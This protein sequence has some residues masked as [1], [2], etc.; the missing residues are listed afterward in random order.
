M[1]RLRQL[2]EIFFDRAEQRGY[3]LRMHTEVLR[4]DLAERRRTQPEVLAHELAVEAGLL[5]TEAALAILDAREGETKEY[6]L[7]RL[8]SIADATD[9]P[10]NRGKGNAS[11]GDTHQGDTDFQ[12]LDPDADSDLTDHRDEDLPQLPEEYISSSG[13]SHLEMRPP[14]VRSGESHL[15]MEL[16]PP[17]S[18]SGESLFDDPGMVPELETDDDLSIEDAPV[19]DLSAETLDDIGIEALETDDSEM[20]KVSRH[21][22]ASTVGPDTESPPRQSD[23]EQLPAPGPGRST[24]DGNRH[25]ETIETPGLPHPAQQFRFVGSKGAQ[26]DFSSF[27]EDDAP[28]PEEGSEEESEDISVNMS[29]S[30]VNE[31]LDQADDS[32]FG[33]A[34]DLSALPME[35]LADGGVLSGALDEVIDDVDDYSDMISTAPPAPRVASTPV[36]D[37][38]VRD[39]DDEAIVLDETDQEPDLPVVG[40]AT[41]DGRQEHGGRSITGEGGHRGLR[42]RTD[43]QLGIESAAETRDTIDVSEEDETD[44]SGLEQITG[45]ELSLADLRA[46]MG[47]GQG[48]KVGVRRG[49]SNRNAPGARR[50]YTV[51]R[52]IARGG[53]GKIIEV[54]DNDLRRR[55]ALKILRKE[56]LE[57]ADLVERFL[58][59]AQITGQLEHPNIVPVHE[60]G[61][62]GKGNLYFTMK[63]VQGEELSAI[64]RRLRKG[65]KAAAKAYPLSR[66]IDIYLKVC[67]GVAFAHSNGVIHRDLKPANIMVGRY[68]EVQI[69]DW[70][71]AKIV[72]RPEKSTDRIIVSDRREDDS[73]R[74]MVGSLLGT[75]SYMSPEQARGEVDRMG[76]AS[77]IFSLGT[78]LYQLLCLSTPWPGKTSDLVIDQ[79]KSFDPEPPSARAPERRIPPELEQL[80]MKCLVKQQEKRLSSAQDLV[81]NLRSWQ[82]GRTLTAV[83]YSLGQLLGK[84]M[85]RNKAVVITSLLVFAALIAGG[86]LTQR[87]LEQRELDR[88]DGLVAQADSKLDRANQAFAA[89]EYERAR[90][91]ASEARD[92]F[93]SAAVIAALRD[94]AREAE[95]EAIMLMTRASDTL[96]ERERRQREA[97]ERAAHEQALNAALLDARSAME[98]ARD[99]HADAL[100]SAEDISQA[101]TRAREEWQEVQLLERN[102]AEAGASIA[103]IETMQRGLESRRQA[104]QDLRRLSEIVRQ[105]EG[106]LTEAVELSEHDYDRA[107]RDLSEVRDLCIQALAV[108]VT[109]EA[110][111]PMR[112]RALRT[113][114][115]AT[116]E[117]ANR[118][119]ATQRYA[120]A[121]FLLPAAGTGHLEAEFH[122]ARERLEMRLSEQSR[123][124]QLLEDAQDA[125]R[126]GEWLVAVPSLEAALQEARTSRYAEPG[127]AQ[128]VARLLEYAKIEELRTRVDAA[129][130]SGQLEPLLLEFDS[131]IGDLTVDDYI[132]RAQRHRDNARLNLGQML[133]NEA[134]EVQDLAA[135]VDLYTRSLRH[136]TD[137]ALRADV[138]RRLREARFEIATRQLSDRVV[139]LPQGT[140]VLGSN[141]ESDRNPQRQHEH[142]EFVFMHRNLVTNLEFKQFV[143]EGGYTDATHWPEEALPHLQDFV[144]TTGQ[145]GPA[146]WV[147]GGFDSSLAH[148]PVTGISWYEAA[149]YAS[150]AGK[151]LPT[152]EEWEIAA[153]AQMLGESDNPPDY[154]FGSRED[155]PPGGVSETREVGSTDW[156]ASRH[157]VRDL[158]SNV[159][160]WTSQL[161]GNQGR[162]VVK[163]AEPGMGRELFFRYARRAKNSSAPLLD[164][165]P[166]RGFRCMEE[167]SLDLRE[168]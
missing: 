22:F 128:R 155:A 150:W 76:P 84:W 5:T 133:V 35:L 103:Q 167:L 97:E 46:Q 8:T 124:R 157:G 31:L 77:D 12:S 56:M 20:G 68:G 92:D 29:D 14:P 108:P 42:D 132:S 158:G 40:A 62:D 129:Q 100:A 51:V 98:H 136:I 45:Q 94:D 50:R 119:I 163:G 26:D 21:E 58:E 18:R 81:E 168:E 3:L 126:R 149:A 109:G 141:R 57:R 117:L 25:T 87:H 59:E 16:P 34:A 55:V 138:R 85:A 122:A 147:D 111:E 19:G 74:T 93:R 82:E 61:V 95:A 154:A 161:N 118:A 156:D 123:F 152:P 151:R 70:G 164:R 2:D 75:P 63:L 102:N 131:L 78:I 145:P 28:T 105:A 120:V 49:E 47:L 66:L 148:H 7:A 165:S 125:V 54:E 116:L 140:F 9:R 27:G 135:R 104:E 101:L 121:A 80:A 60:I 90:S 134:G 33:P 4:Q 110:A 15:E 41:E 144:D 107:E 142:E 24:V 30:A 48:V 72:G 153:G 139:L 43:S 130:T 13:E 52:Q 37:T 79:V 73:A 88:A 32:Y 1:N 112:E 6:M 11:S 38:Q 36:H 86:I 166:G 91:L 99:L 162:A 10:P 53:M 67:E 127:D 96:A 23:T 106:K 64:I 69:M 39:D 159:A 65:D 113:W 83:K 44:M 115:E 114:A 17:A 71:V 137:A 160:E 89:G 143:E 146:T